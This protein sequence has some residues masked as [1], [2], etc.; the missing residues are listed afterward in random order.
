MRRKDDRGSLYLLTALILG[1]SLGFVYGWLI[2]PVTYVKT[3]PS[4]LRADFK[5]RYRALIA[6]AF[7][8]NKDIGLAEK[9]LELLGDVDIVV[10]LTLQAQ[11]AI[12]EVRSEEEV[13]ALTYLMLAI[14]Q[15][16][17][18]PPLPTSALNTP[19]ATPDVATDDP[20]ISPTPTPV[21]Q[22]GAEI[23]TS[24]VIVPQPTAIPTLIP[25]ESFVLQ[26][27][28]LICDPAQELP[29]LQVETLDSNQEAL[30]GIEIILQ[31]PGGEERV[32]TGLK[33]EINLGYADFVMDPAEKY[34]I[35]LGDKGQLIEVTLP[36][37]PTT[38]NEQVWGAWHMIFIKP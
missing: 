16:E 31:W 28:T 14:S 34:L 20:H 4:S 12:A 24:A 32:Y 37:C 15:G 18:P 27:Q 8:Y 35:Q 2:S 21:I 26:E 36:E 23:T 17:L 13:Q 7:Y 9:R 3:D 5:D 25:G 11:R 29:L 19:T 38:E 6:E 10:A 30:S 33:P 22:E 1:V